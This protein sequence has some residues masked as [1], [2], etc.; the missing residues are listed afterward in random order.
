M[1][2]VVVRRVQGKIPVVASVTEQ[3]TELAVRK[4]EMEEGGADALMVLPPF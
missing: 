1:L 4:A 2:E 3:S